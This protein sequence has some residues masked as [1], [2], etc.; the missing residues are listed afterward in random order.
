[1]STDAQA[2]ADLGVLFV[3]GIGEQ[4]Q[5][6]T[7][8]KFADPLSRWLARWLSRGERTEA[9]V[10]KPDESQVVLSEAVLAGD[11]PAHVVM[12]IAA[13]GDLPSLPQRWLLAESWWAETF[14]PPKANALLAWMLLI[15]PYVLTVQ[16]YEQLVR[17]AR[18]PTK[19]TW[20]R[21]IGRYFRVAAFV[22]FYVSALPLAALTAVV[23]A[24]LMIGIVLPIPE[25]SARAKTA[26]LLLSN[27]LGDSFVLISS[28]V[29]FD[30][31]VS[32]VARDLTWLSGNAERVVVLAHSQGAAVAYE[33][34][35]G[36]E[37]PANLR[38]FITIGEAIKKLKLVRGL[39]TYGEGRPPAR[40]VRSLGSLVRA[41]I[42]HPSRPA[43]HAATRPLGRWFRS[44]S[45]RF[46]FGWIGLI[47]FYAMAYS[48]PQLTVVFTERTHVVRASLLAGGGFLVVA[49]VDLVCH[50]YWRRDIKEPDPLGSSQDP[51]HWSDFYASADPVSNGPLFKEPKP[52]LVEREVWNFASV[53]RDH[54]SYMSSEDDF[55]GCLTAE[56]FRARS[57]C[58]P[59]QM[60][61]HLKRGRWRGWWR[62]WWL[63]V[64]RF[65]ALLTAIVTVYR[66][67]GR[68]T[69]IGNRV[70]GWHWWP[71]V[72]AL[73]RYTISG[74]R[75]LAL[76]GQPS[77]AQLVGAITVF[78][79]VAVGYGALAGVWSYWQRQDVKRFY[80]QLDVDTDP[81]GGREFILF[82]L[83]LA[84]EGAISGDIGLTGD[85]SQVWHWLIGH[86][87][88]HVAA[89]LAILAVVPVVLAWAGRGLLG[90]LEAK[91]IA[92][93]PRET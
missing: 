1:M 32:R 72:R 87:L 67:E 24:V 93:F 57:I 84:L 28:A 19:R 17:A 91:L 11:D 10:G 42:R 76:V 54:T 13:A 92:T 85:Y 41:W 53:V 79:V 4:K 30:A 33:A 86:H 62:V 46:A 15:L 18:K 47:G 39:Q 55:I 63:T 36:Y 90:W 3:H 27:T 77:K 40:G 83:V 78:A 12:T 45:L 69:K 31:M 70:I 60:V 59:D 14:E 25:V 82:L 38:A 5:G 29:Q 6:Q 89:A 81:L 49:L 7:L 74:L 16:F 8:V 44:K 61:R 9:A 65:L 2:K 64:T 71:P 66:V 75:K 37:S 48:I 50:F 52:W 58:L 68:I 43:W 88:W 21:R 22:V 51:L 35:S 23:I 56:L 26:A 20:P 73:G 80:R 34:I